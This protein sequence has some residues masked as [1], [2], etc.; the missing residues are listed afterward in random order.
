M[1]GAWQEVGCRNLSPPEGQ[2]GGQ[3]P[4]HVQ[5]SPADP[6]GAP[7]H[8]QRSGCCVFEEKNT[9]VSADPCSWRWICKGQRGRLCLGCGWCSCPPVGLESTPSCRVLG[10]L[11][12]GP[13]MTL[14]WRPPHHG[15][16]SIRHFSKAQES[17]QNLLPSSAQKVK[18]VKAEAMFVLPV[19]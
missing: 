15:G 12:R 4:T 19:V 2:S 13:P 18:L 14:G 5:F 16:G 6:D 7:G 11:L 3:H 1:Q 8:P 10:C 9:E 17:L